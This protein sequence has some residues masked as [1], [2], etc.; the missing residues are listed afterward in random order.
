MH[1]PCGANSGRLLRTD[2]P[3]NGDTFP[4]YPR[5]RGT[6]RKRPEHL[7]GFAG[8]PGNRSPVADH[9]MVRNPVRPRN[10]LAQPTPAW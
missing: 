4:R 9:M 10:T 1:F 3:P 6:A 8:R 2:P 5:D 7:V